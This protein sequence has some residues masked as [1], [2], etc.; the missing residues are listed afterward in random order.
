LPA[1]IVSGTTL[2]NATPGILAQTLGLSYHKRQDSVD[3]TV[4]GA[5]PAGL[6]AAVYGASEGLVTILLDSVG[7]GGQAAASSRIENYVGFP[8]GISGIDL[9]GLASLQAL[10]FG[11]Q[12]YAPCTVVR[13]ES[14]GGKLRAVLSDGTDIETGAVIVTSGAR[15]RSLPVDR[16]N[17][18]EGAGIYYAAT[19]LEARACS[20][21][22]V[23]VVG[24]ANSAGQAALFL[25]SRGSA[26]SLVIRGHDISAG[27]SAYLV[28][29]LVV[30]PQ[31][32]ILTSTEI[33]GLGGDAELASIRRRN[34]I[35]DAEDEAECSGLFCFIG[36]T[37]ATDWLS[38]VALEPDG[39][40]RTDVRITAEQLGP[41]WAELGR[42]PLPFETTVPRVFAAGDVRFGSMKR[43]AAAVGEG[44]SAVASVHAALAWRP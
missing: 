35:N 17:E 14:N 26:V 30:H 40:I 37:P 27:M 36:A 6:A 25:A 44:A 3:L 34:R 15:Y 13:L 16:W 39:F 38:G 29:R 28:E 4:V 20:G 32:T 43:V 12:L 42:S 9:T 31:V 24:G 19:E 11:A 2:R 18:F 41:E 23:A 21:R 22:P 10:K 1:V 5:G 8:N 33:V 7:P